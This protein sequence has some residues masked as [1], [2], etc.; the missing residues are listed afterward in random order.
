MHLAKMKLYDVPWQNK[1]EWHVQ[2]LDFSMVRA[3]WYLPVSHLV[4]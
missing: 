2:M 1:F 3:A 4:T